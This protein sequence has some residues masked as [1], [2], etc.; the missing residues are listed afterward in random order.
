[1]LSSFGFNEYDIELSVRGKGEK[2]K[3]IGRDDVWEHA[4]NA[5]KVA[6]DKK[7]FEI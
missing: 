5:L 2:E 7:G 3:Y 4:E 1:M 6:L